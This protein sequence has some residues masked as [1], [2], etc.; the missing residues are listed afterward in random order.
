MIQLARFIAGHIASH[1][2]PIREQRELFFANGDKRPQPGA[3]PESE[4]AGPEQ[5]KD[6]T[7]MN[8]VLANI[9]ETATR[10]G[11]ETPEMVEGMPALLERSQEFVSIAL[12]NQSLEDATLA[13]AHRKRTQMKQTVPNAVPSQ[14]TEKQRE[15]VIDGLTSRGPDAQTVMREMLRE[16]QQVHALAEATD[17][18]IARHDELLEIVKRRIVEAPKLLKLAGV[19]ADAAKTMSAD[20]LITLFRESG[21]GPDMVAAMEQLDLKNAIPDYAERATMRRYLW[22]GMDEARRSSN[23][24]LRSRSVIADVNDETETQDWQRRYWEELREHSNT[25]KRHLLTQVRSKAEPL[26][27]RLKTIEDAVQTAKDTNDAT[28]QAKLAALEDAYDASQEPLLDIYHENGQD[29]FL[30][31]EQF[32]S[33]DRALL[34][35]KNFS[36][37]AKLWLEQLPRVSAALEKAERIVTGNATVDDSAEAAGAAV[38]RGV[39]KDRAKKLLTRE[40]WDDETK[41]RLTQCLDDKHLS[42]PAYQS[43]LRMRL[44][45]WLTLLERG[46]PDIV[47][48][49]QTNARL[50]EQL[51]AENVD[52]PAYCTTARQRISAVAE[53]LEPLGS[54]HDLEPLKVK[55]KLAARIRSVEDAVKEV[56]VWDPETGK[57]RI[58][59]Q[60]EAMKDSEQRRRVRAEVELELQ[61]LEACAAEVE[62]IPSRVVEVTDAEEY[63]RIAGGV[64]N[65]RACYK[66][67]E[68]KIYINVSKLPTDAVEREKTKKDIFEHE[69]GHALKNILQSTVLPTLLFDA[70][71]WLFEDKAETQAER[72]EFI[73][74]LVTVG[75]KTWG[76]PRA[77]YEKRLEKCQTTCA[78]TTNAKKNAI[79]PQ[80]DELEERYAE[81]QEGIRRPLTEDEQWLHRTLAARRGETLREVP[82]FEL[83]LDD[84]TTRHLTGESTN[85]DVAEETGEDVSAGRAPGAPESY[86]AKEQLGGIE[87]MLLS[88]DEFADANPEYKADVEDWMGSP[89]EMKLRGAYKQLIYIW[90]TGRLYDGTIVDPTPEKSPAY[91]NRVG[92]LEESVKEL[93]DKTQEIQ[94]AKTD[95]SNAVSHAEKPGFFGS[96]RFLSISDVIKIYNDI[97]EDFTSQWNRAQER[98]TSEVAEALTSALP[99]NLPTPVGKYIGR[100]KHYSRRRKHQAEQDAVHKWEEALKPMDPHQLIAML[101]KSPTK[102]QLKAIILVLTHKGHMEWNHPDLWAGL[103]AYSKYRMPAA[104]K[105]DEVLRDMWLRKICTDIWPEEKEFYDHAK[106]ENESTFEGGKKRYT[107]EVDDYSNISGGMSGQLERMLKMFVDHHGHPPEEVSPHRYEEF[108]HFAMR[109]GKMS[110]EQKM[111]YVVRGAAEGLLPLDRLR[112]LAGEKGGILNVFPYIEYFSGQNNTKSE[113]QRINARLKNTKIVNGKEV[114]T[115]TPNLNTTLWV[116]LEVARNPRVLQRI[117]KGTSKTGAESID[118][119]DWPWFLP[120]TGYSGVR[121]ALGIISGTR[122]KTSPQARMN[123]YFGYSSIFK[124]FGRVADAEAAGLSRITDGDTRSLAQAITGYIDYDNI[125][126]Q[127]GTDSRSGRPF[128]TQTDYEAKPPSGD[129]KHTTRECRGLLNRM[130]KDVIDYYGPRIQADPEWQTVLGSGADR[131][132][133]LYD[134]A[135]VDNELKRNNEN[136]AKNVAAATDAFSRILEKIM[137]TDPDGIK[138]IL[139]RHAGRLAN[140]G[141]TDGDVTKER[142]FEYF[143]EMRR[144]EGQE[145]HFG[146]GGH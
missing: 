25:L 82:K 98:K 110:M 136:K 124:I 65:S 96:I 141:G 116:R 125:L 10:I 122:Q 20:K 78:E 140:E 76:Y 47:R 89:N 99:E 134:F 42:E 128:L 132:Q 22:E 93:H 9:R 32:Q 13:I 18:R 113:L 121:N 50:L 27:T 30:T 57:D 59:V 85:P 129:G 84:D 111:Y 103:H 64:E 135:G 37:R 17:E 139:R 58:T 115:Y 145:P 106:T 143:R 130:I 79:R 105:Y 74:R 1:H 62:A 51:A 16:P 87:K 77:D 102:D 104:A 108:I 6:S 107:G 100:L 144:L 26:T 36:S 71:P 43:W 81:W 97:K 34:A 48:Q 15:A 40:G 94:N 31:P 86:D 5:G 63:L 7:P 44:S 49:T 142:T 133:N 69:R 33:A 38:W 101:G 61:K 54:E 91:K 19:N 66:P 109:N 35:D 117:G 67:N 146:G 118:H 41:T 95:P 75:D 73:E 92:Q 11:L 29:E 4:N 46:G 55:E 138:D 137:I 45:D 23:M 119:E 68:N 12:E 70:N 2:S 8:P 52:M 24:G 53:R 120:M 60:L 56:K 114:D 80:L 88:I 123:T 131:I 90:E 127:N 3:Q 21:N 126:T 83:K 28:Y 72:D 14:W 112:S 39:T